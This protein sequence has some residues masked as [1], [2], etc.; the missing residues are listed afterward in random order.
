M[1]RFEVFIRAIV[2]SSDE[3]FDAVRDIAIGKYE[4]DIDSEAL[5]LKTD[6]FRVV[7]Y[8]EHTAKEVDEDA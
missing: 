8:V 7:E 1:K 5:H 2:E 4:E 3:E 6:D